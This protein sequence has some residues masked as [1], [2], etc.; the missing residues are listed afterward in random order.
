M[1]KLLLKVPVQIF[2]EGKAFIAYSPVLEV[3][4]SATTFELVKKRF[5][6][7]VQIFFEELDDL[8]TT[9]EV[10][11]NLGWVKNR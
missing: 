6:Q 9:D 3:S 5:T 4:T 2:K 11:P 1:A 10:L 7:A 8:G